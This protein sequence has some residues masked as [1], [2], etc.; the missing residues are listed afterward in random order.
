MQ[1]CTAREV[2]QRRA[3]RLLGENVRLLKAARLATTTQQRK[4]LAIAAGDAAIDAD[5][6]LRAFYKAAQP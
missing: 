6:A 4:E 5:K 2:L 3:I 1:I